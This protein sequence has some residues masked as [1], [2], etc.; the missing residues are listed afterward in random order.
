VFSSCHPLTDGK[1]TG[2]LWSDIHEPDAPAHSGTEASLRRYI[3]SLE[4][5][6]PN[7]EEMSALRQRRSFDPGQAFKRIGLEA[8]LLSQW[9]FS[10][11]A[12]SDLPVICVETRH[13]RPKSSPL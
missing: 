3:A 5:G 12:E 2:I 7:Y 9:L 1:L 13:R 11:L 6:Q 4:K 8:G 10:A